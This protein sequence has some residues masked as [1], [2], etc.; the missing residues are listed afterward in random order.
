MK[1]RSKKML[2]RPPIVSTFFLSRIFLW[3]IGILLDVTWS[4]TTAIFHALISFKGQIICSAC[5]AANIFHPKF[6]ACLFD[7]MPVFF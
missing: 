5:A 7:D 3:D 1:C 6:G 4:K 2:K